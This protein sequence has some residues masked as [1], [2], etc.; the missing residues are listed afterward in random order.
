MRRRDF[1]ALG[2][3]AVVAGSVGARAQDR[4][5]LAWLGGTARDAV[6]VNLD[7]FVK[8]LREFGY[9]DGKSI[10][11]VSRWANGDL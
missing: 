10:Q 2:G 8:G 11:I 3:A 5:V 6:S 7:A 9:E 4:P 1:I